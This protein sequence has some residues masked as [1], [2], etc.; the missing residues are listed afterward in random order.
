MLRR[1]GQRLRAAHQRQQ[2]R[3]ELGARR[4]RRPCAARRSGRSASSRQCQSIAHR[5]AG[6]TRSAP[7][8][9]LHRAVLREQRQRRNRLAG[10][11][12]RQVV[13]QRERRALD[14]VDRLRRRASCGLATQRCTAA[15]L[16]RSTI[17]AAGR[18]TSSSAPT[19]W[20]ICER[21]V[22]ST[23][24]IDRV[25]VGAADAPRLPSGSGAATCARPRASGAAR[26]G[27]RPARSGRRSC[28]QRRRAHG[29]RPSGVRRFGTV[30]AVGVVRRSGDLES[31]HR[32]LQFLGGARQL[33]HHLRRRARALAGLL[34]HREDVL[35]VG[36]DDVGRLR[37][38]ASACVRDAARS[39]RPAGASRGRSRRAP[40]RPRR[41]VAFP[42]PRPASMRSI[43]PTASCVSV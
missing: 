30:G 5:S 16:A 13:E 6:W 24:G 15:S 12:A 23:A 37:L 40:C 41:T 43:A 20:W 19:P 34:G 1:R 38:R 26:P 31:R 17:A 21:A 29:V 35:D 11:Q 42:R 27:P 3:F 4:R 36:G 10:E 39:G 7:A 32:L 8:S 22:R 33:A 14:V 9:F 18:P 25:D 2:V 28:R